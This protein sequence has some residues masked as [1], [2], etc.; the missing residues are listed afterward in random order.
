MGLFT[1]KPATYGIGVT[2][3]Q[4]P[5]GYDFAK[6]LGGFLRTLIGKS[7]PGYQGPIDPG[8]S[9]SMANLGMMMQQRTQSQLPQSW[10]QAASVLGRFA[11]PSF[12]N[13]M[14]R[15]QMGAPAYFSVNPNQQTYGG[16]PVS[17][18]PQYG[19]QGPNGPGMPPQQGIPMTPPGAGGYGPG[20]PMPAPGPYGMGGPGGGLQPAGEA[21]PPY[22]GYR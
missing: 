10:N 5:P 12:S 2:P 8:M 7:L 17:S 20:M 4:K 18:Y 21:P 22:T 13:P 9:P 6:Y 3:S 16:N 1:G 14:A 19:M 11:T 15:M